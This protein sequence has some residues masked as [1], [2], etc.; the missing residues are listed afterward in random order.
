MASLRFNED[1]IIFSNVQITNYFSRITTLR[2]IANSK[3]VEW[4]QFYDNEY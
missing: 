1:S 2:Q 4:V 3:P